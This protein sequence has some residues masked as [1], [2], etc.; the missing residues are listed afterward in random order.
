MMAGKPFE[1]QSLDLNV[2]AGGR[3]EDQCE[4]ERYHRPLPAS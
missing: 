1:G 2:A 4:E 3:W